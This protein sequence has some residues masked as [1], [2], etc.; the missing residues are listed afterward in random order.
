M[1][2]KSSVKESVCDF[3]NL[4]AALW[5]CKRN[6]GWKDSVAGYV[7]NGL[8]NCLALKEQLMKGT[9]EL[10]KY[11]MFKVYEPKERDIVSTRI[12]DRVFQRSLC[13]NYLTE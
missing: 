11:T 6:V 4:Y 7:K 12:K 3:G 9:Y 1:S 13:D 2:N 5:V 10:S 8:V